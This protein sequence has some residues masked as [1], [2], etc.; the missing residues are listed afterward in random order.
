MTSESEQLSCAKPLLT[1]AI[2]TYNRSACLRE[3]LSALFDQLIAEP[4]VE[5]IVSDNASPDDTPLVVKEFAKCGLQLRYLRNETNIGSDANFLQCFEQAH[6]K[7][8]WILSDDDVLATDAI[9]K[10]MMYLEREEYDLVYVNS[11]SFTGS[12]TPGP[13]VPGRKPTKFLDPREYVRRIHVFFTF[14]SGNIINKDRV[15]AS[16]ESQLS[17]LVGTSLA[18]L[19]WTYTALN[20]YAQGLYIHEKLVGMRLN[21]TGGYNALQVFGPTLKTVTDEWLHSKA[22]RR[23]V[24]NGTILKFWPG[25]LLKYR[26]SAGS[27]AIEAHPRKTLSS[28]F[29]NNPRYWVFVYPIHVLPYPLAASW[30]F[31]VRVLNRIDKS[32][33]LVLLK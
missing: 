22:L 15:L 11:Y 29:G 27:F 13:A 6:G 33:G 21:N 30:L 14:I 26:K 9:P 23:L 4:R 19:G 7:Y 18:Q 2:P 8:V 20:G 5:L 12:H 32:F 10:I 28:A 17:A 1:I 3:L 25:L 31:C 16:H 24:F